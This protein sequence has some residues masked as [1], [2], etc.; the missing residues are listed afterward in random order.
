MK[1]GEIGKAKKEHDNRIA[2]NY[3]I[4]PQPPT[5]TA[6]AWECLN[7]NRERMDKSLKTNI[8]SR[9]FERALDSAEGAEVFTVWENGDTEPWKVILRNMKDSWQQDNKY[10]NAPLG[11]GFEVGNTITWT[12]TGIRWVIVWQ[13]LNIDDYFRGEIQRANHVIRWKNK[14]GI[15]QQQWAAIQGPVETRAK[16][17]QTRGNVITGRQNDTVEIWMGMNDPKKPNIE[18]LN[19]FDRIKISNR[20]WRIQVRDDISNPDVLRFTCVE[21]FEND[22]AD[23]MLELIPGG[24]IDFVPNETEPNGELPRIVGP[25]LVKQKLISKYYAI[26]GKEEIIEGTWQVEGADVVLMTPTELQIR[27][28]KIGQVIKLT[29]TDVEGNQNTAEAKTISMLS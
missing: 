14:N 18:E 2:N 9:S 8:L 1:F 20:V 24:K 15:I 28:V 23:D 3:K 16:Y 11:K 29:F 12:R 6:T 10:I 26:N 19:R 7:T 22:V 25:A 13:D 21:D 17:E 5:D 27:G 4:Q